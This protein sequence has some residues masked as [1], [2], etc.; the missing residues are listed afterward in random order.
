[1]TP[2]ATRVRLPR[3]RQSLTH[4]FC[5]DGAEGYVTVGVYPNGKPGELFIK[6]AKEGSTMSG[7]L[8]GIATTVSLCLQH[9]VPL[10]TLATKYIGTQFEPRGKTDNADIPMTTSV[11]DYVFRWLRLQFPEKAS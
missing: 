1:M 3:S 10:E 11:M 5:I 6:I 8:D 7:L 2:T 4:K 9:G